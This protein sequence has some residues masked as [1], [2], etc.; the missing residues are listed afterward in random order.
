MSFEFIER[1]LEDCPLVFNMDEISQVPNTPEDRGGRRRPSSS[2]EPN[3]KRLR[4]FDDI[5]ADGS[6]QP[7][8]TS[9]PKINPNMLSPSFSTS[10]K[11]HMTSAPSPASGTSRKQR[12]VVARFEKRVTYADQAMGPWTSLPHDIETLWRPLRKVAEFKSGIYPMSMKQQILSSEA[13]TPDSYFQ[14][15]SDRQTPVDQQELETIL[16]LSESCRNH[17]CTKASWNREVHY[18]VLR[19]AVDWHNPDARVGVEI[20]I[21]SR[22]EDA[23]QPRTQPH[24][25]YKPQ[26][27]S[28]MVDYAFVLI[29]DTELRKRTQQVLDQQTWDQATINPVCCGRMVNR[30]VVVPIEC[31]S[32]EGAGD[33]HLQLVVWA[34][35]WHKRLTFLAGHNVPLIT[36]PLISVAGTD[37]NLYFA[38]DGGDKLVCR[39]LS[40]A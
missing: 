2:S 16:R 25:P 24:G 8:S 12:I 32:A 15:P 35:A 4:V 1:W 27:V 23:F 36:L 14:P 21:D 33:G 7:T 30:P 11:I 10:T 9:N 20:L 31:K 18:P 40:T 28:K 3:P 22:L 29:P 39:L 38:E 5:Q 19:A 26:K 13:E 6:P 17:S 34:S 37:W